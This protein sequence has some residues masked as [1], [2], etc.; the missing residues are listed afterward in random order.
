MEARK[1]RK[2]GK[3][4]RQARQEGKERSSSTLHLHSTLEDF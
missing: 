3:E 1:I 2:A 4:Q